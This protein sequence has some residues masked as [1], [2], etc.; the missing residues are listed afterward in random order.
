MKEEQRTEVKSRRNKPVTKEFANNHTAQLF[1][2]KIT[3][4]I[5]DQ[6]GVKHIGDSHA[7]SKMT[8]EMTDPHSSAAL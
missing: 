2:K 8:A 5:T 7:Y 1:K 3:T 6:T 4:R